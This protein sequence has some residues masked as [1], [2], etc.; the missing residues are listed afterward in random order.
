M[1]MTCVRA[2]SKQILYTK[3]SEETGAFADQKALGFSHPSVM[4]VF[5]IT[6]Q[7]AIIGFRTFISNDCRVPHS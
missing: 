5:T 1:I 3:K 2:H 4:H 7:C 6:Y